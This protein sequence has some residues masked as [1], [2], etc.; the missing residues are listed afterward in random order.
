MSHR[1]RPPHERPKILRIPSWQPIGRKLPL[2][3]SALLLAVLAALGWTAYR[4]VKHAVLTVATDRLASAAEQF[5]GLIAGSPRQVALTLGALAAEP[6]LVAAVGAPTPRTVARAR[7]LMAPPGPVPPGGSPPFVRALWTADCRHLIATTEASPSGIAARCPQVATSA[8]GRKAAVVSPFSPEGGGTRY[9][10]SVPVLA[11]DSSIV[12]IVVEARSFS[13]AQNVDRIAGLIGREIAV[14]LGNLDGSSWSDLVQKREGPPAPVAE[15]RLVSYTDG[16]GRVQMGV[17]REV[18]GTPWTAWV[19][20]PQAAAIA[21]ARRL[22]WE[23]L[24]AAAAC[25]VLGAIGAWLVGRHVSAPIDELTR[26][27]GALATG[28]YAQRVRVE[29]GDELGMLAHAFNAMALRVEESNAGLQAQFREASALATELER[30]NQELRESMDEA[31][32]ARRESL[33]ARS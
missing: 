1:P 22:L 25:V 3:I 2:L 31:R 23:I 30:T 13:Q 5:G 7:E 33:A 14:R 10:V 4:R 20:M 6:E 21:P 19:Q 26:A 28:N 17:A 32:R 9:T 8:A 27:A 12:G 11:P 24:A 15:H 16:A 29:R 18:P